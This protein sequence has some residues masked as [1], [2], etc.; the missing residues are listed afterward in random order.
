[1]ALTQIRWH[2][3]AIIGFNDYWCNDEAK[4]ASV[5]SFLVFLC[6]QFRGRYGMQSV[7]PPVGLIW[8]HL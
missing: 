8:S 5:V 1:M 3:V 4:V 2:V 7:K 6:M